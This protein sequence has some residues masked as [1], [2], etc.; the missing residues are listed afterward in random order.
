MEVEREWGAVLQNALSNSALTGAKKVENNCALSGYRYVLYV[1]RESASQ[2]L[3][4]R[5]DES[6]RFELDNDNDNKKE[7]FE[8]MNQSIWNGCCCHRCHWHQ[9]HGYQMDQGGEG[10]SNKG[11]VERII[12]KTM[13]AH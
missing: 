13:S 1:Q 5:R 11:A 9:S 10:E 8:L 2:R 12:D 7:K 6:S 3:R 4:H